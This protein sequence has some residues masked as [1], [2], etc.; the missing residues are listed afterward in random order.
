MRGNDSINTFKEILD[1]AVVN[2]VRLFAFAFASFPLS[3][4]VAQQD[5]WSMYAR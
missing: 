2:D 1:L 4:S 3:L 5:R